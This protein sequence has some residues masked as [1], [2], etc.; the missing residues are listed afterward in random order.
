MTSPEDNGL[1]PGESVR[2]E[3]RPDGSAVIH[4]DFTALESTAEP[5]EPLRLYRPADL[6][7]EEPPPEPLICGVLSV[8][9]FGPFGGKEKTLKTICVFGLA[10][11]VAAGRPAFGFAAWSVPEPK[12]VLIYAGEGGIR[13]VKRRLKRIAR[14]VYGIDNL[15]TLPLYVVA[16]AAPLDGEDFA[17]TLSEAV[18]E[19]AR[20]HGEPPGWV[21]LD[22]L[23]NYH[24]AEV[25][26]SNL[27]ARGRML[28][29]FQHLAH[30]I[31]G[32]DCVLT[33]VDHFRKAASGTTLDEYQQS[34]MGAWADTWWN[35]QHREDPDLTQQRFALNVEVGGRAGHAGLYEIDIE[36]GPFDDQKMDWTATMAVEIRRVDAHTKRQ[37]G[38]VAD[39]EIV[40]RILELVGE[41][42]NRTKNEIR[43]AVEGASKNRVDNVIKRLVDEGELMY[44]DGPH[45]ENGRPVTRPLLKRA[46]KVGAAL[47]SGTRPGTRPATEGGA[48]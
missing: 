29:D 17:E 9:S 26:V 35:A 7:V 44:E 39:D 22:A 37:R 8:G 18:E 45:E 2:V 33:V 24:P 38:S 16:G 20:E 46:V 1:P 6:D 11:A 47:R 43:D 14:E 32:E 48:S 5:R 31:T 4:Y 27:Y 42:R 41:P 19:I 25:E 12:P 13:Q 40:G 10:V 3:R 28:S 21:I 36:L 34:G 30:G 23:Y 15:A